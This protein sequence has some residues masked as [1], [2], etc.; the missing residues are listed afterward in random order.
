MLGI[1]Y[2]NKGVL[3]GQ[4][5]QVANGGR[6][7]PLAG[8]QAASASY[9]AVCLC[10]C[11]QVQAGWP[12]WAR[13]GDEAAARHDL[14]LFSRWVRPGWVWGGGFEALSAWGGKQVSAGPGCCPLG[15]S[16]ASPS[17]LREGEGPKVASFIQTQ[18]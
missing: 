14:R 7:E 9:L 3:A 16:Q 12:G 5:A 8:L 11:A 15:K 13:A 17:S 4:V 6:Q 1:S 18:S 2:V 10:V